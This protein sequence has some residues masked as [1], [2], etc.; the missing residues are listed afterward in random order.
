MKYLSALIGYLVFACA[1]PATIYFLD[2]E[3]NTLSRIGLDGTSRV[4]LVNLA[5]GVPYGLALDESGGKL[6]W[7]LQTTGS[8]Y[9]QRSDINGGGVE[10]L[11][12]FSGGG[13]YGAIQP[14]GLLL[15]TANSRIYFTD[16]ANDK[17]WSA[18]IDG[19]GAP[20]LSQV[21][22]F[23][24]DGGAFTSN[25]VYGIAAPNTV[26]VS[27]TMSLSNRDGIYNTA[28]GTVLSVGDP[29]ALTTD[30]IEGKYYYSVFNAGAA[31]AIKSVNF[32]GTGDTVLLSDRN[33]V[34]GGGSISVRNNRMYW[35]EQGGSGENGIWVANLDGS[36]AQQIY[37][38]DGYLY[39]IVVVP[40]PAMIALW[41]GLL[42]SG[43]LLWRRRR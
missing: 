42:A 5:E 17:L 6:Y 37:T 13:E 24:T 33:F 29:G 4:D 30:P 11:Y 1:C 31:N 40:E 19:G 14:T 2:A 35:T 32:D 22:N 23:R 8:D 18:A 39:G 25:E 41:L 16:I 3:N 34:P 36:N 9:I 15:D 28:L 38:N 7:T 21:V 26:T 43:W 27:Y 12:T 10:T 20:Q